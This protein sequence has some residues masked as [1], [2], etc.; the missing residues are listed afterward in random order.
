M[1]ARDVFFVQGQPSE[2]HKTVDRLRYLAINQWITADDLN[3]SSYA[4][5]NT[6]NSPARYFLLLESAIWKDTHRSRTSLA[7]GPWLISAS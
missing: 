3:L 7:S 4:C 2:I 5:R 1:S 6:V